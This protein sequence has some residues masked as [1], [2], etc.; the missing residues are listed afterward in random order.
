FME[1]NN[2]P[3]ASE[4]RKMFEEKVREQKALQGMGLSTEEGFT[5]PNA[6]SAI[7]EDYVESD[8]DKAFTDTPMEEQAQ[9]DPFL[10]QNMAEV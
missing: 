8:L 9:V 3:Y 10:A 1:G 7:V 6:N 4:M 5:P 2:Y